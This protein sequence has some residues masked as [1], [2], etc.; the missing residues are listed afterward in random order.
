MIE[1]DDGLKFDSSGEKHRR[2]EELQRRLRELM[3]FNTLDDEEKNLKNI[4]LLNWL[5]TANQIAINTIEFII[6]IHTQNNITFNIQ[7]KRK[8]LHYIT[9]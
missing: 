5:F 2:T 9:S 7:I 4:E 1:T 3:N 6:D 8:R